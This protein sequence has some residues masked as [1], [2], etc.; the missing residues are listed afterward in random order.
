MATAYSY[1][2]FSSKKQSKG[3]SLRRQREWAETYCAEHGHTLDRSLKLEDLA[4]SSFKGKNAETGALGL[5]LK[6]CETWIVS[7]ATRR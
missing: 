4:I 1:V 3:D 5:F 6:A 2:R 7:A